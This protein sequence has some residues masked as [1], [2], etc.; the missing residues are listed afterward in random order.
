MAVRDTRIGMSRFPLG[1]ETGGMEWT[2]DLAVRVA[3]WRTVSELVDMIAAVPP[4]GRYDPEFIERVALRFAISFESAELAIDRV[5]GGQMR[6]EGNQE[7]D[8]R[9]DPI[10]HLAYIRSANPNAQRADSSMPDQWTADFSAV[11]AAISNDS[12]P[13][14]AAGCEHARTA[15]SSIAED[16]LEAVSRWLHLVDTDD[17][18][19]AIEG[20]I[21]VRAL[22]GLEQLVNATMSATRPLRDSGVD[23]AFYTCFAA[24]IALGVALDASAHDLIR[25]L[26]A[27]AAIEPATEWFDACRLAEMAFHLSENFEQL[28][29]PASEH[30][31]FAMR[32]HRN[33]TTSM[34][35]S[36]YHRVGRA[37]IATAQLAVRNGHTEEAAHLYACLIDDF[38]E[39]VLTPA[40][41]AT[42]APSPHET[43]NLRRLVQALDAREA[44]QFAEPTD[45]STR[46]RSRSVLN[47]TVHRH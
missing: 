45:E 20:T 47:R 15:I 24:G 25:S 37:M 26:D 35:G 32:T 23:R 30:A 31:L 44:I 14:I 3:P 28:G 21:S 6:A 43:I 13:R 4:A 8:A 12:T 19:D 42:D 38:I 10:A 2:H 29:Q 18:P 39:L 41:T 40:E 34:L 46:S 36:T 33:V 9:L 7:P 17:G 22:A 1:C 5:G 11:V 16:E 27:P